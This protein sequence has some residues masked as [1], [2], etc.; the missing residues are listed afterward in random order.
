MGLRLGLG[1][2]EDQGEESMIPWWKR[3]LYSLVIVI[4]TA[5]LCGEIVLFP[6]SLS[7]HASPHTAIGLL[8]MFIYFELL[9]LAITLPC[10][11]L[12]TPL[13]LVAT[14][15]NGWR[16]WVYWAIGSI[17]GPLYWFG[18]KLVGIDTNGGLYGGPYPEVCAVSVV[19]SLIYLL[20]VGRAQ[21]RRISGSDVSI[22]VGS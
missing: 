22:G 13:I 14:N 17:L 18:R 12:A 11:L 4:T 8:G 19:A 5:S 15:F 20:V 9:V 6:Y 16:F 1:Y 2:A 10:W 3:L 21:K 7:S